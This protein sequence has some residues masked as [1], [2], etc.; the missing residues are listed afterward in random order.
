M[1]TMIERYNHIST[2]FNILADE[3]VQELTEISNRDSLNSYRILIL[4]RMIESSRTADLL[5]N[6]SRFFDAPVI[7]RVAME[8]GFRLLYLK[9]TPPDQIPS[10]MLQ[11]FGRGPNITDFAR[12]HDMSVFY[13]LISAFAHVD[14]ATLWLFEMDNKTLEMITMFCSWAS[15][16]QNIFILTE[17]FDKIEILRN[18]ELLSL[19]LSTVLEIP[20]HMN[21][22][23]INS[24]SLTEENKLEI[25]SM[26]SFKELNHVLID[27]IN[28]SGDNQFG[29]EK[30][31]VFME[32]ATGVSVAD[33]KDNYHYLLRTVSGLKKQDN[34]S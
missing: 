16:L 13:K 7:H 11:L 17:V 25:I 10:S 15:Y 9:V 19:I 28:V 5:I 20:E 8:H 1:K 21:E 30:L 22:M 3:L 27:L 32:K 33:L 2:F 12:K 24:P 18:T 31:N 4:K 34:H 23:I 6:N 29:P 26:I 14:L